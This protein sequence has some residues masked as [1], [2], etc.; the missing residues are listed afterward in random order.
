[1]EKTPSIR[2]PPPPPLVG[3]YTHSSAVRLYVEY[4]EYVGHGTRAALRYARIPPDHVNYA[5]SVITR[6]P[7]VFNNRPAPP[8]YISCGK[9]IHFELSSSFAENRFF[10]CPPLPSSHIHPLPDV[11]NNVYLFT[12]ITQDRREESFK[13]KKRTFRRQITFISRPAV[14]LLTRECVARNDARNRN[15]RVFEIRR[16]IRSLRKSTAF[17]GNVLLLLP[18]GRSTRVRRGAGR[19]SVLYAGTPP[20]PGEIT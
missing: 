8:H 9:P 17:V 5:P 7:I 4:V 12:K 2:P 19:P 6:R 13:K 20:R 16:K 10:P 1:M 3:K 18:R 14:G 11:S 15:G